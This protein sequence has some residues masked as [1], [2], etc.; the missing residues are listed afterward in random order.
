MFR[1]YLDNILLTE[2]PEG[3]D[4]MRPTL[5]LDKELKG[6]LPILEG[7]LTFFD[8]GYR[9]IKNVL[10]TTGRTTTI[11]FEC[12]QFDDDGS[13]KTISTGVIFLKDVE[14]TESIDGFF[15]KTEVKDDSFFARIQNNRQLN[16]LCYVGASKNGVAIDPAPYYK[17]QYFNPTNGS[18]IGIPA[19]AGSERNNTAFKVYDVLKFYIDFM[20]DGKVDFVSDAFSD[21]GIF[22]GYL[23]TTGFFISYAT[24]AGVGQETFED[25]WPELTFTEIFKELDIEFNLSF[26]CGYNGARPYIRIEDNEYLYPNDVRATY[27]NLPEIK[28]KIASERFF[29]KVTVGAEETQ[30]DASTI[31][32]FGLSFPSGVRYNYTSIEEY[33]LRGED[34]ND[35]ALDLVNS[36]IVDSNN[37][38]D[39]LINGGPSGSAPTSF[40]S[41]IALIK[42]TFSS[43]VVWNADKSNW[44]TGATTPVFY[45]EPLINANKMRRWSSSIH[46][47]IIAQ[48][49]TI[50]NSFSAHSP[51]QVDATNN[52][53]TATIRDLNPVDASIE[54]SDPSA[55]YNP[56]SYSY[57]LPTDG[58]YVF[59]SVSNYRV[60]DNFG[61]IAPTCEVNI[62][63]YLENVTAGYNVQIYSQH[64][65]PSCGSSFTVN[66][67]G[68]ING[69]AGDEIQLHIIFSGSFNGALMVGS[70]LRLL[71][72]TTFSC[73]ASADSGGIYLTINPDSASVMRHS[74]KYPLSFTDWKIYEQDPKGL[75]GHGVKSSQVYY[76]HL[77]EIKYNPFGESDII[78]TCKE[79]DN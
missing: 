6:L 75:I 72:G 69:L 66:A 16:S 54:D 17:I 32:T 49:Q 59:N 60:F 51:T 77:E 71:P 47:S 38:E 57:T 26:Q 79:T 22:G 31:A 56:V 30:N 11:K 37:I 33:Y 14:F 43:G 64:N 3:W 52:G 63:V 12:R 58:S 1:F 29:S 68:A 50:D 15:C 70:N 44:L 48:L 9:Y 65:S 76:G 40:Y 55:N 13:F 67:S 25:N 8:D 20:T 35:R 39:L 62:D 53:S 36:W 19:G 4:R 46:N 27:N 23:I 18:N 5:R 41:K 28:R 45:N 73:T 21:D 10:A 24:T 2:T 61:G 78:V 74:F 42:C 7:S 34:N